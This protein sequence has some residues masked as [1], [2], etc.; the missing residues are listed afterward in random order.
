MIYHHWLRF[1]TLTK[2][3]LQSDACS[4]LRGLVTLSLLV[5][6]ER[7]VKLVD[8]EEF[9]TCRKQTKTSSFHAEE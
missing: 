3:S 7:L 2:A 4:E 9:G 6:N 5:I 1:I 8:R